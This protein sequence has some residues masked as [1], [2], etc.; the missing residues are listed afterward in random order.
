MRLSW[1]LPPECNRITQRF[2]ERPAFDPDYY[3]QWGYPGHPALDIACKIGTETYATHDGWTEPRGNNVLGEHIRVHSH[4]GVVMTRH[5]HLSAIEV[6]FGQHVLKGERLG[7]SGD[8]GMVT[9]PHLDYAVKITGVTNAPYQ[10]WLD[11]EPYLKEAI[12]TK[13]SAFV[14]RIE[15]WMQQ[16]LVDLNTRWVKLCNPPPGPDPM[17]RIPNKVVRIHTD[18]IDDQFVPRGE[19]GGRD[20]VRHMLPQWRDRPWATC[21]SLACGPNSDEIGDL[22]NLRGY[23]MGAIAEAEALGIKLAI[24]DL[25]ESHPTGGD[26]YKP[27]VKRA[28]LQELLPA[29]QLA[30]ELGH[31]V[32]LQAYWRPGV[33]GPLGDHHALGDLILK[34]QMW[35]D[36]GLDLSRLRLFVSEWGLDGAVG[37]NPHEG[38]RAFVARGDITE[39]DYIDG[40]LAAEALAQQKP[41]LLALFKFVYGWEKPW[42]TYNHDEGFVRNLVVAMPNLPVNEEPVNPS[43]EEPTSDG[44]SSFDRVEAEWQFAQHP[45]TMKAANQLGY[46]WQREWEFNGFY[47]C[48]VY[49]PADHKYKVLKLEPQTW[50]VVATI[51]L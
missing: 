42:Q 33:E 49:S 8:T 26:P 43:P 40:L 23:S 39:Q 20:F 7:L 37:G 51:D 18:A 14:Q 28:K 30:V 44:F 12:V 46:V 17:P 22:R 29:V 19:Q 47:F 5:S 45:A 1:P 36:M 16:A 27:E 11:P 48:L 31:Y 24:L 15:P 50:Q 9:G 41:W 4:D 34:V 35:G 3:S 2:G 13:T 10:N 25:F 6:T 38:W 32:A 21:H